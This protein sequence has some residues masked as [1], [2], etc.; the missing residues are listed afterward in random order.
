MAKN[1]KGVEPKGLKR[2]RLAHKKGGTKKRGV[3]NMK[4]GH[5]RNK[6][7][8][9]VAVILGFMPLTAAAINDIQAGGF[10]GLRN[11]VSAIV[12]YDVNTRKVTFA[13]LHKGLWPIIAGFLVHKFVGGGL[14]LNRALSSMGLPWVRI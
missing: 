3:S 7:T 1:K 9:P 10:Q 8:L 14:G 4:R 2:Y 11:T 13:Y 5:R 6:I 12:P